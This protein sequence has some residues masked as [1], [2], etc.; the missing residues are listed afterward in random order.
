VLGQLVIGGGCPARAAGVDNPAEL[1]ADS[2]P[3]LVS[4]K[5]CPRT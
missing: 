1:F 4:L 5:L 2:V 3:D